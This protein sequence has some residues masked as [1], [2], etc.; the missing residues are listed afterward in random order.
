MTKTV[1]WRLLAALALLALLAFFLRPST[2]AVDTGLVEARPIYEAVEV[3]GRTRGINPYVVTAPIA[4]RLLRPELEEGD[5]VTERQVLARS[6]PAPQDP[7]SLQTLRAN[8]A[9]AEARQLAAEATLEETRSRLAQASRDL[10]RREQLLSNNSASIEE[11]ETYRQLVATEQ[12][13]LRSAEANLRAI[14]AKA[15]SARSFLNG[16]DADAGDDDTNLPLLS[17]VNG[18][19]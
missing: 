18:T 1:L 4:G 7:R 5:V 15:D 12:A 13:R 10:E 6:A 19:V 11:T 14:A 16:T 2:L 9:A 8:V 17:P 3:Q